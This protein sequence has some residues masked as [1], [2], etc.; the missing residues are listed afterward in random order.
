MGTVA[1]LLLFYGHGEEI[2]APFLKPVDAEIN[3]VTVSPLCKI[4]KSRKSD[5][6]LGWHNY[7]YLY[8]KLALQFL[9]DPKNVFELGVGTNYPDIPANMGLDGVPGASLRGWRDYFPNAAI[10]GA[11]IDRRILFQ[12]PG[13]QTLYVDQTDPASI[14]SLWAHLPLEFDLMVDD[15]LHELEANRTFLYESKH[16]LKDNGLYIIEDIVMSSGNIYAFDQ[17]L[18]YAH[19]SGFLYRVPYARNQNDNAVAV[20]CGPRWRAATEPVLGG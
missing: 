11:D 1:Q 4:M 8:H 18:N 13:I 10:C 17:M 7:T 3:G 12:E 5:K 2:F 6:G 15:G 20:L 9:P 14:A 16:K 19:M